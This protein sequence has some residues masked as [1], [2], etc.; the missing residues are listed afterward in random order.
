MRCGDLEGHVD[1]VHREGDAVHADLVRSGGSVSIGSGWMYSKSSS[2]PL[3]PG[4]C[5][6]AMFAWLPSRPTAM[7]VHSPRTVSRPRTV[8][9]RSVKKEIA[10][11]RSRTAMPTF[12]ARVPRAAR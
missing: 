8:N 2:R 12:R 9:P 5:N 4:V 7:S 6:I 1:V 10:A 11:S 3:P